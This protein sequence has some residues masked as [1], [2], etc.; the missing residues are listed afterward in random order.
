M[1][2]NITIVNFAS[3]HNPI[4]LHTQ[5][6]ALHKCWCPTWYRR[7]Y[8]ISIVF[9]VFIYVH[10]IF[11]LGVFCYVYMDVA[12]EESQTGVRIHW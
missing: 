8:Y 5:L 3:T 11:E 1:R 4:C 12:N 7:I 2:S 6:E 10:P 9:F